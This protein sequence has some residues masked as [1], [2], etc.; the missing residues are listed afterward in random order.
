MKIKKKIFQFNSQ[1][2]IE[3]QLNI[4]DR[5]YYICFKDIE[6][7]QYLGQNYFQLFKFLNQAKKAKLY[8]LH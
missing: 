4:W 3:A 5:I 1:A 7:S 8:C 2:N 6:Q